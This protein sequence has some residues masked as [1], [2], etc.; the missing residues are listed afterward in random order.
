MLN[1]KPLVV[2]S[3]SLSILGCADDAEVDFISRNTLIIEEANS[4]CRGGSGNDIETW[5]ACILRE[6]AS[7]SLT[8]N[9]YC[10]GNETDDLK[11]DG[12][13]HKC[14]DTSFKMS[15]LEIHKSILSYY[16][17]IESIKSPPNPDETLVDLSQ[18]IASAYRLRMVRNLKD[19]YGVEGA[20]LYYEQLGLF[21][22]SSEEKLNGYAN[23]ALSLL[24]NHPIDHAEKIANLYI[25]ALEF[26]ALN[27]SKLSDVLS[28]RIVTD[29]DNFTNE[30]ASCL[31]SLEK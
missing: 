3:L 21:G 11:D 27:K 28:I 1:L 6:K 8:E 9:G 13:W 5:E 25:D 29:F 4:K 22:A 18:K 14:T 2:F 17:N 16:E 31:I 19:E 23:C 10:F 12:T 30:M 7:L 26:N 24:L 20:K 15:S